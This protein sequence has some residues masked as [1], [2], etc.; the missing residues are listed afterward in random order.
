[1]TVARDGCTFYGSFIGRLARP[2]NVVRFCDSRIALLGESNMIFKARCG[3]TREPGSSHATN[4]ESQATQ[5]LDEEGDKE[6]AMQ[7]SRS[8]FSGP[9]PIS[10]EMTTHAVSMSPEV[11]SLCCPECEIPLDLHQPDDNEPTQLL[12]ICGSCCKWYFLV[13]IESDWNDAAAVRAAE[14]RGRSARCSLTRRR[15]PEAQLSSISG[16]FS[17]C[18]RASLVRPDVIRVRPTLPFSLFLPFRSRRPFRFRPSGYGRW[19]RIVP[20]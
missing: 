16:R 1:M 9:I 12:G 15:L 10:F 5:F 8:K 7:P 18:E 13:E 19:R 4:C 11:C 2:E 20:A 14:C 6:G 3:L 17:V